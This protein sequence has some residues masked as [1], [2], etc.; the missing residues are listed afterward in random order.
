MNGRRLAY[1]GILCAHTKYTPPYYLAVSSW[2]WPGR[3]RLHAEACTCAHFIGVTADQRA[4][5]APFSIEIGLCAL[6]RAAAMAHYAICR[7]N[8]Q[9][10]HREDRQ[11]K[12]HR[13]ANQGQRPSPRPH[14]RERIVLYDICRQA[15]QGSRTDAIPRSTSPWLPSFSKIR[16]IFSTRRRRC[17]TR[18]VMAMRPC[19]RPWAGKSTSPKFKH[20]KGRS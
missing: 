16:S 13:G 8:E 4:P 1:S 19:S 2:H 15:I 18:S 6:G 17:R 10:R 7:G 5:L 11:Q 3:L 14:P 9:N 20:N 12:T